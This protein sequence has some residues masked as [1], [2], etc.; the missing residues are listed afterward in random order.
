MTGLKHRLTS[1][2]VPEWCAV[3]ALVVLDAVWALRIPLEFTVTR[4]DF[5]LPSLIFAITLGLQLSRLAKGALMAEYFVLTLISS[6]A[7]CALSYLCLASAGPLVD[8]RLMAMDRLLGFDW[9]A[10]YRLVEQHPALKSVL[11]FAYHSLVYQGL[12]FGVL[13]ALMG[14]K[15]RLREMFWM[16]GLCG[17]MACAGTLLLPALGPSKLYNIATHTGFVPVMEHILSG[18]NLR[19]ALSGMTGVVSFPSFHTAMAL[20]YIWAFRG[21]G[22][23]GWMIAALNLVML[24][25]VPFFGGHYLMDMIAGAA[26]MLLALGLIR[27]V[28]ALWKKP[29]RIAQPVPANA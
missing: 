16:F 15:D 8:A 4:N 14:R 24:A 23:A 22:P 10:G 5:L 12:Y 28:P 2:F 20:A 26:T 1:E 19:F 3:S 11:G 21:T 7:I 17:L 25:S 29:S 27:G 13:L 6:T 9:L 18:E